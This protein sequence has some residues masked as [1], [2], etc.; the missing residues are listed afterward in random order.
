MIIY[1]NINIKI[2]NF[3][4]DIINLRLVNV[5]IPAVAA[6]TGWFWLAMTKRDLVLYQ[7]A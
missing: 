4:I 1:V 6:N 2:I 5:I 3:S 7:K